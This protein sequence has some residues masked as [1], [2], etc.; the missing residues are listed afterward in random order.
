M[1]PF[2]G[3]GEP[4]CVCVRLY[5]CYMYTIPN[6]EISDQFFFYEIWYEPYASGG[7]PSAVFLSY[8][9]T[10]SN[11]NMNKQESLA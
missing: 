11:N 8:I 3:G 7:H 6:S 1:P 10:I 9:G 4:V 5:M 2:F